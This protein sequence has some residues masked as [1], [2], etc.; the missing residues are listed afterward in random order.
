MLTDADIRMLVHLAT[1][2]ASVGAALVG[3]RGRRGSLRDELRAIERSLG[4]QISEVRDDVAD[5]S[6]RMNRQES[7]GGS[8]VPVH[9]YRNGSDE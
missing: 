3:S 7:R 2:A 9:V 6:A 1:A 4:Q 8:V 5:L